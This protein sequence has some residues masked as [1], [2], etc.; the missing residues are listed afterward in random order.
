MVNATHYDAAEDANRTIWRD[1]HTEIPQGYVVIPILLLVL[2]LVNNTLIV[3]TFK[4]VKTK[5]FTDIFM[6]GLAVADFIM[7]IP[8][9]VTVVILIRGFINMSVF[10]CDF[11][12]L[13]FVGGLSTTMWLHCAI[14]IEKCVSI[15]RPLEHRLFLQKEYSHRVAYAVIV[16]CM[17][18]PDG[19][20]LALVYSGVLTHADFDPH[21]VFCLYDVNMKFLFTAGNL[22]LTSSLIVELVTNVLILRQVLKSTIQR[23]KRILRTIRTVL[24]TLGAYYLCTGPVAVGMVWRTT[25]DK[26]PPPGLRFAGCYFLLSNS[27]VNFFIY[28]SSMPRFREAFMKMTGYHPQKATN[29]IHVLR[30]QGI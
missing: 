17:F 28:L 20:L 16:V 23:K 9:S 13:V 7:S 22:F 30:A 1:Y 12:A 11:W 18:F 26:P 14:C 4:R 8:L 6:A 29:R 25:A 2:T 27:C 10:L 24:I 15:I 19:Y 3:L 21:A 5:Q